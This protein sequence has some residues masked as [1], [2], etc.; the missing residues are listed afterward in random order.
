[1]MRVP[2][3]IVPLAPRVIMRTPGMP[4]A[5]NSTWKPGGTLI[6]SSGISDGA[7]TVI[8]GACGA[9]LE[10]AA[11][12]GLPAGGSPL[13]AGFCACAANAVSRAMLDS[14]AVTPRHGQQ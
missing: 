2:A 13:S 5:H 10:A 4:C 8:L 7:V 14:A 11:D 12:G 9:S 1:M 6:L 3:Q